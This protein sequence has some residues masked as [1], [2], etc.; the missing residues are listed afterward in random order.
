MKNIAVNVRIISAT[1]KDLPEMIEKKHFRQDLIY[2]LNTITINL[3]PLRDRPVDIPLL[4]TFFLDRHAQKKNKNLKFSA[5]CI[6][7]LASYHW[8]GN[9][10]ELK[11][12]IDYMVTMATGSTIGRNHLPDFLIPSR[13]IQDVNPKS[14]NHGFIDENETNLLSKAVQSIE[15]KIIQDALKFAKNRSA[16]IKLLG[17]SRRTFYSKLKKYNI[18]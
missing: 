12:V 17:T 8:P 2:R 4:S 10:R 11:G 9:V 14:A 13:D 16:A 3:P 1:N 6:E 7:E 5:N 18:I 15:K